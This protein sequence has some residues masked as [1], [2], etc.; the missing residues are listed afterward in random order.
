MEVLTTEPG[1]QF[2][3][4]NFLDGTAKGKGGGRLQEALRLLPGDAALP[5]FDQPAE[6]PVRGAAAGA[7]V[8]DDDGV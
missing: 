3:T 2:Y 6:L 8:S 7:D 5:R 1:M 4:G